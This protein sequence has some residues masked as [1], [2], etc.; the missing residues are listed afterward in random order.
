M[1]NP[2]AFEI[3]AK[4]HPAWDKLS[5]GAQKLHARNCHQVLGKD[6]KTLSSFIICYTSKGNG[7]GGT[8]Q[9]LRIA[10]AYNVPIFDC[11][12]HSNILECR[13]ELN[14]FIASFLV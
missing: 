9:A 13:K 11:G 1:E 14:K 2:K 3:A 8:G 4:F 5:Q 10:K 12:L 6:L 7:S